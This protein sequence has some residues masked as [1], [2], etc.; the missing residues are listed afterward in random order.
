[1]AFVV[2]GASALISWGV[3]GHKAVAQIAENHLTPKAQQAVKNIL[4]HQTL[5]DVSS[6]ADEIRSDPAY[7]YTGEWHYVDLTAGLNFE[8]F[9]TAVKTMPQS[10]VYKMVLR[11]ELDLQSID[12]SKSDKVTALKY[13]VHLIG[14]L[15]QPMHVSHTEDKGGNTIMVSLNDYDGNL[16]GLWDSGIIAHEGL[17]YKQMAT[18]YDTATPEQIKKW[19]NDDLMIWLWESY[20]ISEILYK[21]AAENPHFDQDYYQT[22]TPILQSRIEKGGIRLAGVLNRLFDK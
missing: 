5:A 14:D 17:D 6:W 21:E 2:I 1:M 18:T 15:H 11:C 4:G 10:N 19:Q 22:H 13:L 12:K 16:H 9:A 7:K 8:Q 20:Q 3:V